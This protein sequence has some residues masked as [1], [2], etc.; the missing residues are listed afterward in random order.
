M[1]VIRCRIPCLTARSTKVVQGKFY[2][3]L[4]PRSYSLFNGSQHEGRTMLP[5]VEDF[6]KRF[7]LED[8]VVVA[9]SGLI[10]KTNIALL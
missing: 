2:H 5:V 6:V 1:A 7:S 10:N 3:S 4:Q 8:F 9:G